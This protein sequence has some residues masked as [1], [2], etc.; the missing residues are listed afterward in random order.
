MRLQLGH[1]HFSPPEVSQQNGAA[2]I[3][4]T[5]FSISSN[6]DKGSMASE[7]TVEQVLHFTSVP[8]RSTMVSNFSLIYEFWGGKKLKFLWAKSHFILIRI[9]MS[10]AKLSFLHVPF[11][12]MQWL[13]S[14]HALKKFVWEI[15]QR[16]Q[17]DP[18]RLT[19]LLIHAV[20]LNIYLAFLKHG[21]KTHFLDGSR[22]FGQ[23]EDRSRTVNG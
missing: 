15:A 13:I 5:S 8:K 7:A 23:D 20:A 21:R 6:S 19:S 12:S 9:S 3:A 10:V 2:V 1:S 22:R 11:F 16:T 18:A 14:S 4:V 17:I